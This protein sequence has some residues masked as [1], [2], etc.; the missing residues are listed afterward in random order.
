MVTE[1]QCKAVYEATVRSFMKE[2]DSDWFS[3][4]FDSYNYEMKKKV[5]LKSAEAGYKACLDRLE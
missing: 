5:L 2:L 3:W 4:L 1:S